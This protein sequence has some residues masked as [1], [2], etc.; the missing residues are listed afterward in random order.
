MFPG[1]LLNSNYAHEA[2]IPLDGLNLRVKALDIFSIMMANGK[3][4]RG[5][6]T[7]KRKSKRLLDKTAYRCATCIPE[8]HYAG[9]KNVP[10]DRIQGSEGRT[11]DFDDA[12]YPLNDRLLD[13]WLGCG[14]CAAGR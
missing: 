9:L 12:F 7:L 13:R 8:R 2:D 1:K 11:E 3:L 6:N 4:H 10:I 5:I 14:V